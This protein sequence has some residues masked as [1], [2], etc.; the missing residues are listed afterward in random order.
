MKPILR[1]IPAGVV[2]AIA[3][4]TMAVAQSQSQSLGDYARAARKT[5]PASKGAA[6]TYDNDNL[7][8]STS[9]SVVGQAS[10]PRA[11][12]SKEQDSKEQGKDAASQGKQDEK[13]EA[14]KKPEA[15]IK[16]GQPAEER[17]KALEV[18]K[19]KVDAQKD[20][21]S[22]LSRELDVL[23]REHQL[24][25]AEFYADTAARVSNPNGFADE[26]A[27]YKQQIADKQKALDDAKAKFE[28][29]QEQAR[30]AGAPNSG[31]E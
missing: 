29:I 22:L 8:R 4:G 11:D 1:F 14:E 19:E 20:K 13:S 12:Q 30:K 25:Q 6:K 16:P 17:Q 15:Q 31:S 24:K 2:L 5:K 21:V 27:K 3:L 23:Q 26:D 7:P 28:D 18:W 9:I 10:E